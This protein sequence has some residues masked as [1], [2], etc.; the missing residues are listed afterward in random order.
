MER[1]YA[2][3]DFDDDQHDHDDF[4]KLLASA[5]RLIVQKPVNLADAVEFPVD[6]ALPVFQCQACRGRTVDSRVIRVTDNLQG[7]AGAIDQFQN[8]DDD[9]AQAACLLGGAPA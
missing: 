8:V 1:Q 7:V 2:D 3:H 6:L 9:I 5:A 4:Q